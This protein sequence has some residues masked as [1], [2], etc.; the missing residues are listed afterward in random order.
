LGK[1]ATS[2]MGGGGTTGPGEAR[3]ES[4][5]LFDCRWVKTNRRPGLMKTKQKGQAFHPQIGFVG[6]SSAGLSEEF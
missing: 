2:E 6:K 5:K 4:Q 1:G 3:E